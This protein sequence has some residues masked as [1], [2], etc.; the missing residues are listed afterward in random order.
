M[1]GRDFALTDAYGSS[2]FGLPMEDLARLMSQWQERAV[3]LTRTSGG[4]ND[5]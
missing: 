4:Q 3:G 1:T 2:A 5:G